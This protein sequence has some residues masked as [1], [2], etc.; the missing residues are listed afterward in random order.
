MNTLEMSVRRSLTLFT[1]LALAAS[2]PAL[3]ILG[4]LNHLG[5]PEAAILQSSSDYRTLNLKADGV[6]MVTPMNS[7]A[8]RQGSSDVFDNATWWR[9]AILNLN[10]SNWLVSEDVF[11]TMTQVSPPEASYLTI[12]NTYGL[13]PNQAMVYNEPDRNGWPA[14]SP[15][16]SVL[17]YDAQNNVNQLPAAYATLYSTPILPT[18]RNYWGAHTYLDAD[19]AYAM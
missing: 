5:G 11:Q 14:N 9:N 12:R 15:S 8:G 19:L 17:V 4:D 6:W 2:A 1:L 18:A 13:F 16:G 3:Q 10:G 7:M